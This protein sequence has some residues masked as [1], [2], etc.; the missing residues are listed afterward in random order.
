[1]IKGT[2][3]N[4]ANPTAGLV[5]I[6]APEAKWNP[7]VY[8]SGKKALAERGI[9]VIESETA[10][11]S[12]L[13]LAERPEIIA[14]S[15]HGMF[16][17]PD[18]DFIMCTGGGNCMNKIIPH[19]NM[20]LIRSNYKPF[21]GISDITALLLALLNEDMVSFHGPFVLWNYGVE[22]TPTVFTHENLL[23]ALSGF[24]GGCPHATNW[25]A[26]RQGS[27]AGELI[28]G[29]ISTISNIIGTK[30]C[31][32]ELF[33]DKILFIEDIGEGFPA[34]DAKLTHLRL[35]GVFDVIKGILIG[36]M[37]DCG[38]P[39]ESPNISFE[40]FLNFTF[41]GVDMPIVY[42][43]DFGHVP[44]NLCLPLGCRTEIVAESID[45]VELVLLEEGVE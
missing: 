36:K 10:L 25:K 3:L 35:L 34:L 27:A 29:N 45:K 8:E 33:R 19:L 1:M 32:V 7:G 37:P 21:I 18:V 38:P 43:C 9:R 14:D 28:G 16:R 11:N 44:D 26:F 15:L 41:D 24:K 40:E 2:K 12:Y 4:S 22:G 31:P 20:S 5:T 17:N 6:S 39:E 13:Y 42:D 30:Y 23:G